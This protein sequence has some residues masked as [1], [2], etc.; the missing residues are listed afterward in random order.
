MKNYIFKAYNSIYHYFGSCYEVI[1]DIQKIKGLSNVFIGDISVLNK[2]WGGST[3][4]PALVTGYLAGKYL[5][6]PNI[7]CNCESIEN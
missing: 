3:S 4:V 7:D 1:D 2:P 5:L 6:N